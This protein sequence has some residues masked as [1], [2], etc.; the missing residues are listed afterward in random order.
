MTILKSALVAAGLSIAATAGAFAQ[1]MTPE[2]NSGITMAVS[3]NGSLTYLGGKAAK[4]NPTGHKMMM[5]HA[6][7]LAPGTIIYRTGNDFYL[8]ENKIIDGK[9]AEDHAKGW[10]GG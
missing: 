1:S 5:K 2:I 9:M 7:R 6:T 10:V 4:V 3:V 8:L